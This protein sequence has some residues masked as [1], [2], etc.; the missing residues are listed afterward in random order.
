MSTKNFYEAHEITDPA[1]PVIFHY[2]TVSAKLFCESHWHENIEML[3]FT[4]GEAKVLL[5]SEEVFAKEGD[6][7]VINSNCLHSIMAV[8]DKT[9]YYCLIID[10]S[11]YK[12]TGLP[13]LDYVFE[14]KVQSPYIASKIENIAYENKKRLDFYKPMIISEITTIMVELGRNHINLSKTIPGEEQDVQ[15]KMVKNAIRYIQKNLSEEI[16]LDELTSHLGYSKYYFCR[17]F[18]KITGMTPTYYINFIRCQNARN[19]LASGSVVSD[20]A[21]ES[22][23]QNMS[24]FTKKYKEITGTLP[25]KEKRKKE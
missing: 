18:K 21:F 16:S 11:L 24:Y 9:E 4:K 7:I 2:D 22:G 10:N 17:T 1:F 20:A 12:K 8:T 13:A 23:F 15:E 14:N 25:S 3:L 19:L 6:I 5:N